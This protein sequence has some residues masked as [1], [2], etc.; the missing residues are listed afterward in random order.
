M[1]IFPKLCLYHPYDNFTCVHSIKCL[2]YVPLASK[3]K[4]FTITD[5][6]LFFLTQLP[7][8]ESKSLQLALSWF[9]CWPNKFVPFYMKWIIYFI[10]HFTLL[11]SN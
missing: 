7:L 1:M 5:P 3:K 6:L 2:S 8:K 10:K 11:F 9:V 4:S